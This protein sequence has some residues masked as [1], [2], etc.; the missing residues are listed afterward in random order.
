[1]TVIVTSRACLIAADDVV[2]LVTWSTLYRH[3]GLRKALLKNTLVN[4]FLRDGEL[5]RQTN[6][7]L[8]W[9]THRHIRDD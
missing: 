9:L 1:M 6:D 8:A 5:A 4:V 7:R 3:G 2:I